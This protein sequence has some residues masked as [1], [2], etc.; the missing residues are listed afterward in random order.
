MGVST[1]RAP[2][3][4]SSEEQKKKKK[5]L[6]EQALNTKPERCDQ[7]LLSGAR[8]A[9]SRCRSSTTCSI[10]TSLRLAPEASSL[11]D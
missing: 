7:A 11:I 10:Q 9:Q 4:L 1:K 8:V 6:S 3:R 2:A 5:E